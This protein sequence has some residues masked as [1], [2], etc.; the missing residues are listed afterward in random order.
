MRRIGTSSFAVTYRD[1][2]FATAANGMTNVMICAMVRMGP[3]HFGSG[4]FSDKKIW[5]P[6]WL[7]PFDLLLNQASEC[8]ASIMLLE[9]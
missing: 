3:F 9:R 6:A 4:S 2:S 1:L 7:R 8:A 5:A